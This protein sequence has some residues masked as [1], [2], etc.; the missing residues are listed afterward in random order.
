[1]KKPNKKI[2]LSIV[3]LSVAAVVFAVAIFGGGS[4]V[5]GWFLQNRNVT[6]DNINA[7]VIL[8]DSVY[9]YDVYMYNVK[10]AS[11]GKATTYEITNG[12]TVGENKITL[13]NINL[14]YYDTIFLHRNRFTSVIVRVGIK[15]DAVK[16]SGKLQINL[17]KSDAE[18]GDTTNQTS[19]SS[20]SS[21]VIR[22]LPVLGKEYYDVATA[23]AATVGGQYENDFD[24]ALYEALSS[25]ITAGDSTATGVYGGISAAENPTGQCFTTLTMTVG[26]ET[27]TRNDDEFTVTKA[28]SITTTLNYTAEDWN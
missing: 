16:K 5:F 8:D 17:I 23:A 6:N 27:A 2:V 3:Q 28:K 24:T 7:G 26:G 10:D 22:F 13:E 12:G 20:K 1:M 21:S 25:G 9:D 14:Q 4:V 15:G 11:G 18:V 19:L